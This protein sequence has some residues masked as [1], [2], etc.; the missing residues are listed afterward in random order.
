MNVL[1]YL[2]KLPRQVSVGVNVTTAQGKQV[3]QAG[4]ALIDDSL[5]IQVIFPADHLPPPE[6]IDTAADCLVFVE[7]G[8]MVTLICSIEEPLEPDILNLTLHNYIELVEK[9][10]YFRGPAERLDISWIPQ[11]STNSEKQTT[12]TGQGINISCGGLFMNTSHPLEPMQKLSIR[13]HLPAPVNRT[14]TCAAHTLRVNSSADD[15]FFAALQFTDLDPDVC[16][17]IMAFCFAEQRRLLREQV[18]TRDF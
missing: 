1:E 5:A 7:T 3:K 16:D 4:I 14:V 15:V 8:E 6:A 2:E 11:D 13:I 9:R 17:D 18:M 12:A 10:D